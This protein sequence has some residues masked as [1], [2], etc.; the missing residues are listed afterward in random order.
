MRYL[1]ATD[2]SEESAEAV[3]H[4]ARHALAFDAVLE[5]VHVLTPE[6]EL[7]EGEV[8]LPGEDA[9]IEEGERTLDRAAHRATAAVGER[10]EALEV[11]TALLT[12]RPADAIAE[13]ARETG[14]DAI[15]VGHRG[16][17]AR[18]RAVGSVARGVVD[19]ADVP[20]TVV[21]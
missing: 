6:A 20:V 14:A 5:L 12:G 10:R 16:D 2:G 3:R 15:F 17:A 13:R 4:A 1:A 21:R 8:V 9:A 11:E 19:R 7:V 18:R